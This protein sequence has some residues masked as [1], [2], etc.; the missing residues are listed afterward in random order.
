MLVPVSVQC[1]SCRRRCNVSLAGAIGVTGQYLNVGASA[2]AGAGGLSKSGVGAGLGAGV[3]PQLNMYYFCFLLLPV[4][5][6]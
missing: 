5:L 2:G 3:R 4:G 1:F 6:R